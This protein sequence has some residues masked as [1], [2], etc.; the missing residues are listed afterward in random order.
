MPPC[1]LAESRRT[2]ADFIRQTS[3]ASK[4]PGRPVRFGSLLPSV[5][6][7][8]RIAPQHP[9]QLL[10]REP[11]SQHSP[12]V[13]LGSL[14]ERLAKAL[15]QPGAALRIGCGDVPL[16]IAHDDEGSAKPSRSR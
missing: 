11:T 5:P 6:H 10:G 4:A 15:V 1:V 16:W 14:D 2:A 8:P 12:R 3:G 13:F 9:L 7:V